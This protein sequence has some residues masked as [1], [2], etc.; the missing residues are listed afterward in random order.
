MPCQAE[1]CS[2]AKGDM[3]LIPPSWWMRL[4]PFMGLY[5]CGECGVREFTMRQTMKERT[6]HVNFIPNSAASP[7]STST[8]TPATANAVIETKV[9]IK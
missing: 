3:D 7:H 5:E 8:R 1:S 9:P 4:L 2:C 6:I